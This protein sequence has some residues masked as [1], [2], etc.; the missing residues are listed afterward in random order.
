MDALGELET[1]I[2]AKGNEIRDMKANKADKAAIKAAVDELLALKEKYKAANNGVP[3]G[4]EPAKEAPKVKKEKTPVE[5]VK[6]EGP[7]KKELNKLKKKEKKANYKE[8]VAGGAVPASGTPAAAAPSVSN[9]LAIY[10]SSA[11]APVA[12]Y[13]GALVGC[14]LPVL[15]SPTP[16]PHVPYLFSAS[17]GSISGDLNIARYLCRAHQPTLLHSSDAWLSSQVDQWLE[18]AS[19][20][21]ANAISLVETHLTQRTFLVG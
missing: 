16:T 7:S 9:K 15:P 18:F 10:V 2:V 4:G 21:I 6:R 3:Y 19:T 14:V 1:L 17:S 20:S 5:E 12:A 13:V 8:E 11:P